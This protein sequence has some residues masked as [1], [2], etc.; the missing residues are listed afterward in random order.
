VR[1]LL[2]NRRFESKGIELIHEPLNLTS[3]ITTLLRNYKPLADTKKI[4]FHFNKSADI[5]VHADKTYL[6]RILENLLSNALKFSPPNTSIII[7]IKEKDD[8][9]EISIADNGPGISANDQ[10]KLFQ[11]FQTLSARPTGGES[12]TGLGLS[13]AK[14]IVDKMNGQIFCSSENGS[15]ACFTVL[16]PAHNHQKK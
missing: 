11:K 14:A 3:V 12:S 6:N 10:T 7:T 5:I 9:A 1:N 16:I 8:N 2:D 13:I 4:H 15:G